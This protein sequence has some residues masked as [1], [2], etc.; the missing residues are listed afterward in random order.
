MEGNEFEPNSQNR[1]NFTLSSAV[2]C[3]ANYGD[4]RDWGLSNSYTSLLRLISPL[5]DDCAFEVRAFVHRF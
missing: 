1:V 5:F 4:V 2:S 3:E